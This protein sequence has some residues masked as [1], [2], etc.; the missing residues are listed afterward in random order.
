MNIGI[1][2]SGIG[3]LTLA[4]AYLSDPSTTIFYV[5]DT[6]NM[7]YGSKNPEHIQ[8]ISTTITNFLLQNNVDIIVVGC[9]TASILAGEALKKKYPHI[10]FITM[11][12]TIIPQALAVTKN[13]SVG[14][15]ATPATI[16]SNVYRKTLLYYNDKMRVIEQACP[17]LAPSIEQYFDKPDILQH[18]IDIY[19]HRII[20]T[21]IDTLI[22]GCTHY[23]LI[24]NIIQSYAPEIT[25]ISA[26]EAL[27]EQIAP[28]QYSP[29]SYIQ[30]KHKFFVSGDKNAF[31]KK[32]AFFLHL[33]NIKNID[34]TVEQTPW[35]TIIPNSS[36][37]TY[38]HQP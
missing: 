6:A 22:L 32:L 36:A 26:D 4:Q 37:K 25:L 19:L 38:S 16:Q 28:E 15:I 1:F 29:S 10:P 7:P 8:Q 21:R 23:A 35:K 27:P 3:G 13:D 12:D 24:K 20:A 11:Q 34:Y 31:E 9:H 17:T 2:D 14:I 30:R 18:I 33:W 5:A